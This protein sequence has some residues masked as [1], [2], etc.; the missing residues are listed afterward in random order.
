MK[1]ADGAAS[2]HP[3]GCK[4]QL[5]PRFE[6]MVRALIEMALNQ[7]TEF[8]SV[9]K[10]ERMNTV[11]V[12]LYAMLRGLAERNEGQD[13]VEYALVL[14]VIS[15]GAVAVLGTLSNDVTSVFQLIGNDL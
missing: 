15:V 13:L 14:A 2:A 10:V 11:L 3:D 5:P 7:C 4:L 9:G 1:I 8:L 12:R 6:N